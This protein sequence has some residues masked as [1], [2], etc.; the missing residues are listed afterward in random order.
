MP[1]GTLEER[2]RLATADQ[3]ERFARLRKLFVETQ[4]PDLREQPVKRSPDPNLICVVNPG[5]PR[6][7]V[8][9]A[10]FDSAGGEGVIDNWTGA[11]LLPSLAVFDGR[12][13]RRHT[14]EFVGF[15]AEEKGLIGSAAYLKALSKESRREIAAVVAIDSLGLGPTRVWPNGSNKDL[16]QLAARL[17]GGMQLEFSGVNVDDVGTTDSMTFHQAKIPTLS[18][19]SITPS[20]WKIINASTDV[21]ANLSWK[22]YYDSHRFVSALL[23]LLDSELP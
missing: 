8:V 23:S 3:R 6:R 1:A 13:P 22:D 12:S 15:A 4:C 2:L 5:A 10:H 18:L 16:I 9:G 14:F 7:I 11:V 17:A 21:W 19:H 20:N